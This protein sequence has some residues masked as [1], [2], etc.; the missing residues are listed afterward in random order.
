MGKILIV[1]DDELLR[2]ELA[3]WFQINSSLSPIIVS[4]EFS[5]MNELKKR[6]NFDA[7][8]VDYRLKFTMG[9][10]LV[11]KIFEKGMLS[12][13]KIAILTAYPE[14]VEY[15]RYEKLGIRVLSKAEVPK[16]LMSIINTAL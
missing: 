13:D 3:F 10:S 5:A 9:D 1:D 8:I 12:S 16:N 14:E 2:E 15:E 6:K 7:A 11:E 4:D